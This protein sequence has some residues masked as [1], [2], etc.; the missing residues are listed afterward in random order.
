MTPWTRRFG[1]LLLIGALHAALLWRLSTELTRRPKVLVPPSLMSL[2][3]PPPPAVTEPVP[4]P[5]QTLPP[6]KPKPVVLSKLIKP[7]PVAPTTFLSTVPPIIPPPLSAPSEKAVTAP[8]PEPPTPRPS[9]SVA[10]VP[11]APAPAPAP[12]PIAAREPTLVPVVPPRSDAAH[13]NNPAPNYPP[14]SRRTGEQGRVLIDVYI[15]ADGLVEQIKLKKRSGFPR[16]DDAALD[17]VR[18]WRYQPARRGDEAIN[19]W[20]VQPLNFSLDS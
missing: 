4:L 10:L 14:V 2:L 20:Y 15:L 8:P 1:P 9:E 19:F 12:A 3:M 5:V 17:A 18:R 11:E 16:L 13:P 7:A 6:E